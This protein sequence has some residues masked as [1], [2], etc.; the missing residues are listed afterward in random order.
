MRL[1]YLFATAAVAILSSTAM[2]APISN[3]NSLGRVGGVEVIPVHSSC[4]SRTQT[5]GGSYRPHHHD[6]DDCDVIYDD[7]DDDDEDYDDC[8]HNV[9]R[10][11]L[12][13]YGRV[14]HRHRG[15]SCHVELYEHESG[16]TP[17]YG[18]CIQIGPATLCH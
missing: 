4:H 16:P 9:Q 7:D 15:S 1:R 12:S 14:W 2:A 8:H 3:S 6:D 11:Y 5:H 10:H 13:G 18:D 17:G